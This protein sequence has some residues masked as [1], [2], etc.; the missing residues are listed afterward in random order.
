[1]SGQQQ[2]A[3]KPS[4]GA[5]KLERTRLKLVAAIRDEIAASGDFTAERVTQRAGISPATFYNHFGSKDDALGAAYEALMA[6]L[7]ANIES[8]CRIE[9][10]LDEGLDDF[11]SGWLLGTAAFF[12]TNASMFRL[13]QAVIERS[14]PMRDLYRH[15]EETAIGAYQRLIERGQAAQLIRSGDAPAMARVLVVITEGW[16]HP[17]I[18]RLDAGSVLHREMT[19]AVVRVLAPDG[20]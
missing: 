8:Q 9:R 6:D 19:A 20:G 18:Q 17:L 3:S 10:L 11:V 1:M 4:A 13:C 2:A 7:G 15:H 16:Y 14:K 5:G 12:K